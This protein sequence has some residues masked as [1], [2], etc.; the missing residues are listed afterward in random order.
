MD[1]DERTTSVDAEL[2]AIAKIGAA[3]RY[4]DDEA[5]ARILRWA[6]E[7]YGDT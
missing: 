3:L 6:V 4:L 5:R 7:R 2:A 1:T